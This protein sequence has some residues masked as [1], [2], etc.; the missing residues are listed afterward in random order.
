MTIELTDYEISIT[1]I[2]LNQKIETL[3]NNCMDL[4][5][6]ITYLEDSKYIDTNDGAAVTKMLLEDE[7]IKLKEYINLYNRLKEL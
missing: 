7:T 2:L 4:Q 1:M 6:T 5:N 3:K